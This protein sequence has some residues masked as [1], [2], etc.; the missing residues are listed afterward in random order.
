MICIC[1][2]VGFICIF[3][4]VSNHGIDDSVIESMRVASR[5]FF[6]QPLEEKQ[7]Y[8]NLVRNEQFQSEGYGNDRVSSPDQTRDW[9]DRLYLK[10]EP[11]DERCTALWPARKLQ[12]IDL[13]G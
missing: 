13:I 8:N 12:V 7:R 2:Y 6:R 1:L 4:Q 10:V 3:L 9:T 5:E 11:E